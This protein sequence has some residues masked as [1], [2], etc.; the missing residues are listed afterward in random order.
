V[1]IMG[2][3]KCRIVGRSQ[4]LLIMI[5]PVIS[6]RTRRRARQ[7]TSRGVAVLMC[8]HLNGAPPPG[9]GVKREVEPDP[10]AHE[11]YGRALARN[12]AL[13]AQLYP[14]ADV[15]RAFPSWDRSILT[16]IYLMSRLL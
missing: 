14:V 1:E 5:D 7:V 9:V 13:Y 4:P 6:T 2:S 12:N 10:A 16:E 15:R 11:A 8:E 3:Q